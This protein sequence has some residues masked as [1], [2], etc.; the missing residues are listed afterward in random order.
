MA[1]I[2]QVNSM[3]I[4]YG[5]YISSDLSLDYVYYALGRSSSQRSKKTGMRLP[6]TP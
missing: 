2:I 1:G 6:P 4:L 3:S 5:I